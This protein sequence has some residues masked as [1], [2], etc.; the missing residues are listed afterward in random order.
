M[1]KYSIF[2][3]CTENYND[4][5]E[6]FLPSWVRFEEVEKVYVFTNYEPAYRHEK[7][8]YFNILGIEN[9]WLKATGSK[10]FAMKEFL[11]RTTHER[12]AYID[13]D[14][15]L[16]EDISEVFNKEFDIACTRMN[17]GTTS[18]SGVFFC[19]RSPALDVF[20]DRWMR[21]QKEKWN[22]G[23]GTTKHCQSYQQISYSEIVHSEYRNKTYLNVLPVSKNK[24]NYESN[25]PQTWIRNIAFYKPKILHLKGR[26]FRDAAHM[27]KMYNELK[28]V[29]RRHTAR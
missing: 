29:R 21:L 15:Y 4:A 10:A 17:E 27:Q 9:D 18:N 28:I 23:I 5:L 25:D 20:A 2:S 13:I 16:Y 12:F 26:M 14:C 22:K 6:L 3:V 8:I 7:V 1:N 19:H 24:Y 11:K